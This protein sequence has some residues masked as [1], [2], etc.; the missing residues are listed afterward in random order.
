MAFSR[1]TLDESQLNDTTVGLDGSP[2]PMNA[3]ATVSLGSLLTSATTTTTRFQLAESTLGETVATATNGI[4]VN[5]VASSSLGSIEATAQTET[6]VFVSGASALGSIS[7][8]A[9]ATIGNET[10]GNALLGGV[11]AVATAQILSQNIASAL[12]GQLAATATATI[13][14]FSKPVSAAG[15]VHFLHP[16]T[17]PIQKPKPIKVKEPELVV[18]KPKIVKPKPKPIQKV[19][20]FASVMV[21]STTAHAVGTILW[22]AELDDL[23]VLELL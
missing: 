18:K 8:S 5:A 16:A 4:T 23:E 9:F 15:G 19:H 14:P 1:F 17:K 6:S 20:G 2:F 12:L 13:T 11:V 7:A 21:G 22:V 3:T 10:S